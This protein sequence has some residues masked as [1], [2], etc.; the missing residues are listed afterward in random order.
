MDQVSFSQPVSL[1]AASYIQESPFNSYSG[2]DLSFSSQVSYEVHT[3]FGHGPYKCEICPAMFDKFSLREKHRS[4]VHGGIQIFMCRDCGARFTT[5]EGIV[6]KGISKL[7]VDS[8][9]RN[10]LRTIIFS[11]NF[12]KLRFVIKS[13]IGAVLVHLKCGNLKQNVTLLTN[14]NFL[15]LSIEAE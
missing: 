13:Y 2:C 8:S 11:S 6:F 1:I 4:D 12:P 5:F 3:R 9:A 7:R 15:K 14:Q 10:I